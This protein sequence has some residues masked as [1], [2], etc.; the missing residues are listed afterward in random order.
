VKKA[1]MARGLMVLSDGAARSTAR[2]AITCCWR[3]RSS[4]RG[5]QIGEIV[6]RLGGA[7]D[8]ALA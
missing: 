8:D 1:A 3:R 6:D 7:I 5:D 4:S 2:A